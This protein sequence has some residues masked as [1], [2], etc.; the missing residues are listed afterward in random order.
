MFSEIDF[1]QEKAAR[2][3]TLSFVPSTMI[4]SARDNDE[5]E[6]KFSDEDL[7][8]TKTVVL[9]AQ[10]GLSSEQAVE[11]KREEIRD[12]FHKTFSL[13]EE[14]FCQLASDSTYYL[15]PDKLRH[16]LIFYYGHTATF[17]I[18]KL[19]LARLLTNRINPRIESVCAVGV[20]EMSWD[21]LNS[22]HYDWPSVSEVRDY[23]DAVRVAIDRL[24]SE[25][26]LTLPI[27]F[28]SAFWPILMGIEHE[29][30]HLETSSVLFR[31]LPLSEIKQ[32]R[33]WKLCPIRRTSID[34]VPA[35]T[36]IDIPEG[37]V[38]LNKKDNDHTYGWDNEYGDSTIFVKSFKAGSFLVSNAEYLQFM[39]AGGYEVEKYWGQE[40]WKF[41]EFRGLKAPVFW[42]VKDEENGQTSYQ[43]R[44]TASVID[45]PWDW[46][47]DVNFIEARA[48]CAWKKETTGRSI[49]LPT[50]AEWAR[51]R[52]FAFPDEPQNDQPF[53]KKAPGN[54][55]LEYWA[56]SSPIDQFEFNSTGLYDVI[57]NVWQHTETPIAGF[58]GFAVHPLYDDFSAPTFDTR[59]NLMKGGSFISTGNEA[60]RSARYAFRRH[61]YQHCGFRYIETDEPVDSTQETTQTVERDPEVAGVLNAQFASPAPFGLPAFHSKLAEIAV[62]AVRTVESKSRFDD[63]TACDVSLFERAADI[64]CGAGRIAFH[65]AQSFKSVTGLDLTARTIRVAAQLQYN[66]SAQYVTRGEGELEQFNEVNL[67]SFGLF[68]AENH[69]PNLIFQQGDPCNLDPKH[70]SFGLVVAANI[71]DRIY[72]PKRFLSNIGSRIVPRGVLVIAS[73][74]DWTEDLTPKSKWVGG[75]KENGESIDS[76]RGL[77]GLLSNEFERLLDPI[78]LPYCQMENS[79]SFSVKVTQVTV[80]QRREQ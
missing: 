16:P 3:R 48:F 41:L 60:I 58:K 69:T 13:Y 28:N 40:G 46:P 63:A 62:S 9:T 2:C 6:C 42:I 15:Q 65:L 10:P 7:L 57:G 11:A 74:Y 12:Y 38:V 50:E 44:A 78:D 34:Q 39:K 70:A 49:R 29:R 59:H 32:T 71:I 17:F 19:S 77:E 52:D 5:Y 61:F 73:A 4:N 47:V 27:D 18:N 22:N 20:D 43:Y 56:S 21:D 24:I 64:G 35:T 79:R 80:W 53:W 36:M 14:L 68:D 75:I 67:S 25:M 45:M 66:G 37:T 23:R 31:Q 55:N 54:I 72:D 26:P 76:L 51:M 33:L 1:Q 30:I 8:G